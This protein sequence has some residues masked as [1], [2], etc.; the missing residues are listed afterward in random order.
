Q[1]T[2][3]G[4]KPELSGRVPP[5][6][7]H[8]EC[9]R[10]ER[11]N[12]L[13]LSISSM[14]IHLLLLSVYFP[15]FLSV[16]SWTKQID[17][18][19]AGCDSTKYCMMLPRGC[20]PKRDCTQGYMLS[21]VGPNQL[22]VEM[23]AQQLVPSV[24]LQYLSI[25][26]SQDEIMGDDMVSECVVSETGIEGGEVFLSF[27]Q[28]DEKSNNRTRLDDLENDVL[29][30]DIT[31]SVVDGRVACSYILSIRP[32]LNDNHGGCIMDID[33]PFYLFGATGAA[34]PD[35]LNPHDLNRDSFYFPII[36]NETV[37][38]ATIGNTAFV[39][40]APMLGKKGSG[41]PKVVTSTTR[42]PFVV[43][44]HT[45]SSAPQ[46]L[47]TLPIVVAAYFLL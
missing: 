41:P 4:K 39:H 1:R 46:A 30:S 14:F 18:D 44:A 25:G 47:L 6:H 35:E 34:Q 38:P 40:P 36:S 13:P 24:P 9:S 22:K 19:N 12:C 8:I 23:F 17:L 11:S 5:P 20:H 7:P 3:H 16:R 27:N 10:K 21:V 29:F 31:S 43:T 28:P 2:S 33:K 37:N 26:F 15:S 32:Q 45:D 42:R